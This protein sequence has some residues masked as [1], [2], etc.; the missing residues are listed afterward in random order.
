MNNNN[1]VF[2]CFAA[3]DRY[4][5]AQPLVYHLKNYGIDI[6]YDRYELVL[7]DNREE[8]NLNEGAAGCS[9][10]LAILSKH[11]ASSKC[12]MEEL[13]IVESRYRR[14][15]V[16]VFPVL[17]EINPNDIPH[18]LQWIKEIIFKEV[19][20]S[21]GTREICNHIAC[22]ITDD[23]LQDC[24]FKK[25]EEIIDAPL[26]TLPSVTYK[27][28]SSYIGIEYSNLNSR[29]ALLYS[30]Y[31]MLIC[32]ETMQTGSVTAM[33]S[34]IFNRLFSETK[35]NIEVDYRELWLLENSICLLVNCYLA[36][37]TESRI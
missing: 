13:S 32:T 29:V 34:K 24:R 1:R 21:S 5:I 7:S 2:V 37:C 33:V 23:M 30:I 31:L 20:K 4:T 22:K 9:Y 26:P 11:T 18:E 25:V 17:Y 35:R 36:S 6:W 10:A 27:L 19:D 12:A 3:E 15:E 8:K 16:A 28:L 14:G